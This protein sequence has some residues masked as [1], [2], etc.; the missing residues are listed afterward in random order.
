MK[1]DVPII[2]WEET[3]E[4]RA[5]GVFVCIR[6]MAPDLLPLVVA[7]RL[8]VS[9][10]EVGFSLGSSITPFRTLMLCLPGVN[11]LLLI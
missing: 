8:N 6:S 1:C 10:M 7:K 9:R 5:R 2:T 3:L 4:S 11:R